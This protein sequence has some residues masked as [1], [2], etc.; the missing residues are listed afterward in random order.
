MYPQ[1]KSWEQL[2]HDTNHILHW[3]NLLKEDYQIKY[4]RAMRYVKE[5]NFRKAGEAFYKAASLAENQNKKELTEFFLYC[6][7]EAAFWCGNASPIINYTQEM[8][9]IHNSLFPEWMLE[10]LGIC[11]IAYAVGADAAKTKLEKSKLYSLSGWLLTKYFDATGDF[12]NY[13][14]E[15]AYYIYYGY[16]FYMSGNKDAFA[17]YILALKENVPASY[18]KIVFEC[19]K[20]MNII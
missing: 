7:W 20:E 5:K 3:D 6:T 2:L 4:D 15:M 13:S 11:G 16:D 12:K 10:K 9:E 14:G 17:L 19:W 18:V 1:F 8:Y